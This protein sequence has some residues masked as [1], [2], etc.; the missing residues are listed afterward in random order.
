ML[1]HLETC[2]KHKTFAPPLRAKRIRTVSII[3]TNKI[4]LFGL[5][6]ALIGKEFSAKSVGL[7]MTYV[8]DGHIDYGT[9]LHASNVPSSCY[10]FT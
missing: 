7:V 9:K 6:L 4:E 3:F 1:V 2:V 8:Q 5:A 10:T